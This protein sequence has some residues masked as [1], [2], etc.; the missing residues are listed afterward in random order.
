[1]ILIISIITIPLNLFNYRGK[2]VY[3]L[4]KIF[5]NLILIIAGVKVI[6]EGKENVSGKDANFY[7]SNHMSYLDIPILMKALPGNIR[8]LYKSSINKIPVFGWAM[9]LAGYI[10]IDR[11]NARSAISSLKKASDALKRGLSIVIFPEGTRSPD[12]KIHEFKKGLTVIA[13]D[14]KCDI[15]PVTIKG[16]YEILPRG[17]KKIKPGK[18]MV[19]IGNPFAYSRDKFSLNDVRESIIKSYNEIVI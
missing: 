4:Y 17:S 7:I 12:G 16:S 18:V 11:K 8:F 10:P 14:I 13:N 5:G 1:M 9:Y 2:V 19:R 3:V 6:V 15:T